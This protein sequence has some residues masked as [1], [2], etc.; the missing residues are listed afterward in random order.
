MKANPHMKNI[1]QVI[2]GEIVNLP[3]IP[4]LIKPVKNSDYLVVIDLG[5][6]LEGLYYDFLEYKNQPSIPEIDFFAFQKKNDAAHF[7]IVLDQCFK[8]PVEAQEAIRKLPPQ[9]AAKTQILSNW[10]A[11]TVFLNRKAFQR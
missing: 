11:D 3:I 4:A 2:Q 5:I 10:D 7:A 6:D 8:N 9:F 1:H